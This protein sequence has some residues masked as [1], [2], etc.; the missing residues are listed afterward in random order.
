MRI[1]D[2]SSDVCSSDLRYVSASGGGR[3]AASRM[4]NSRAV[5]GGVAGLARNF[6]NQGPAEAL[7]RFN[8]EGMAGAPAEDVFVAL[9][10]MLCPAGGPSYAANPRDALLEPVP[11][12]EERRAWN[13]WVG[14]HC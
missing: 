1:S 6:V 14:T 9:R 11:N 12:M 10:D 8:L 5:A 4:P 3:A 13:E 2:W 7:R